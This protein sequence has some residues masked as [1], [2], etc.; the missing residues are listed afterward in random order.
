METFKEKK[1]PEALKPLQYTEIFSFSCHKDIACF[2]RCCKNV[3]MNLYPY[4]IVR[5]KNALDVSSSEFL[6]KYVKLAYE[7]NPYFPSAWLKLSETYKLA[8]PF[9]SI[10]GCTVYESRPS[11]CRTY[12]LQ[13]AIDRSPEKGQSSEF[14]FLT[15]HEY[16]LG[17]QENI[18][19]DVKTYIR[20]Q[21]LYEYNLYNDLWGRVENLLLLNPFVSNDVDR[22]K[23]MVF[24]A[25]YNID[26]FRLIAEKNNL[27]KDLLISRSQLNA[28]MKSDTEL[29]KFGLQWTENFLKKLKV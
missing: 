4:D 17:H 8:C 10:G 11:A 21:K 24:M 2:T 3:N 5:L 28:I 15:K 25:C 7:N 23:Q 9:L 14:Y 29:L 26:D 20:S 22:Q 16:C 13:R 12:P 19:I 18:Q 1:F 6:Q 27:F